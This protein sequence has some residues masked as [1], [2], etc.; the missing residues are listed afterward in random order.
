MGWKETVADLARPFTLYS[1]SGAS[2][3]A[4]AKIAHDCTDLNAGAVYT[5][6]LLAGVGALYWGKAWE[7][8][9]V[10]A[11]TAEVEK[12]RVAATPPPGTAQ[13]TASPEVDVTIRDASAEERPPWQR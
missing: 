12:A 1:L 9:K 11:H 4:I 7:N 10:S 5:A 8:Q 6:A 3:Y 2:A 13:I